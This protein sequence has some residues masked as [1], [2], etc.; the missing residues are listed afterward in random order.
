[1]P[2]PLP[3]DPAPGSRDAPPLTHRY[4]L[5]AAKPDPF[6]GGTMR[7]VSEREFPISAMMTGALLTIKPGALRELHWHPHAAEWQFYLKGSARTTVFGSHGRVC[8]DEF[9]AHDVGYVP[10]G[11]GHYIENTGDDDMEVVLVL[12]NGTYESVSVT[13]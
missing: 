1:V 4:Q 13:A 3:A 7:T 9:A 6:A 10:Q 5:L 2:P 11:Y 12:N 8:T